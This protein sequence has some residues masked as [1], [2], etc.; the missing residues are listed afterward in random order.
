MAKFNLQE[1]E[2]LANVVQKFSCLYDKS[3]KGYKEI[4]RKKN[5]WR[6]VETS[7]GLETGQQRN[8]LIC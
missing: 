8:I 2:A 1:D 5:A 7:L 3:N 4:D 6:Q